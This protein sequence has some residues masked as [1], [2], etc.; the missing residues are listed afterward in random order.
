MKTMKKTISCLFLTLFLCGC[1]EAPSNYAT[2]QEKLTSMKSY[3]TDAQITYIGNK[4][5]NTFNMVQ[6]ATSSGLYRLDTTSPEE[7][8]G[9]VILYD[10]KMIWQYNPI[11]PENKVKVSTSDKSE[12]TELLLFSFIKNFNTASD[13]TAEVIKSEQGGKYTVLEAELPEK[14]QFLATEKLWINND[15]TL[16]EKLVIYNADGKEKIVELFDNF[17]Y[18]YAM[19]DNIFSLENE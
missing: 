7:F 1:G 19:E 3:K 11:S 2:A 9:S 14:N 15:T 6:R 18:N 13:T 4:S 5:E 17:E 12:R 10:G 8:N 16:P